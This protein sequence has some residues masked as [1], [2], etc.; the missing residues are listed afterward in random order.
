VENYSVIT[1]IIVII[2]IVDTMIT[3]NQMTLLTFS[4]KPVVDST[5]Q[6]LI[7]TNFIDL[8]PHKL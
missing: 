8:I 1:T 6:I 4:F 7:P 5:S 3:V 2:N